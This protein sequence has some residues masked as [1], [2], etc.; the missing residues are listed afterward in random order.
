MKNQNI[1]YYI[2]AIAIGFGIGLKVIPDLIVLGGYFAILLFALMSYLNNRP[3][4][5][6][7]LFIL[8]SY[9]EPYSRT[10]LLSAPYL[11]LQYFIIFIALYTLLFKS[12]N[13]KYQYVGLVYFS[14]FFFVELLNSTRLIELRY[15]TGV[16][17]QTAAMLSFLY[18]GSKLS[19]ERFETEYF[20]EVIFTSALLLSAIISVV[21]IKGNIQWTDASNFET[22][23]GMGP[24]QISFYLAIGAFAGL[25]GS[26]ISK[27][28]PRLIYFFLSAVIILVMIL[29]FS[30]GGLYML[31]V[32]IVVSF[33]LQKQ[34]KYIFLVIPLAIV[35]YWGIGF[36]AD[37]TEG[38]IIE[39][40]TQDGASSRDLLV[41]YG[42]DMFNENPVTGVGTA[43]YYFEVKKTK[44]LGFVSGAH[45]EIIRSFAEH[46]FMGGILWLLFFIV[47]MLQLNRRKGF[48]RQIAMVLF[49]VFLASTFHNGLKLAL[50]SMI[51]L[52]AVAS[53]PSAKFYLNNSNRKQNS[54]SSSVS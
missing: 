15:T 5:F 21:Y 38:K 8:A 35:M 4:R 42:W 26:F 52:I 34:K 20:L 27:G 16:L 11:T 39:R 19:F 6:I 45:N 22:S 2:L 54:V 17:T 13:T 51:L 29:T 43:N 44:Y 40:Y 31:G 1:T 23:G 14:I 3:V 48:Y 10:Y 9:L 32:M 49:T 36:V 24:V 50:Q 46:G 28:I 25:Y 47:S 41:V 7:A 30:R 53:R 18:M 33:F 37:V 12:G